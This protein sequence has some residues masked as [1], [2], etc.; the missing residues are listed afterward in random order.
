M[1]RRS[2]RRATRL[3]DLDPQL[4]EFF[5]HGTYTPTSKWGLELSHSMPERHAAWLRYRAEILAEW[6]AAGRRGVPWAEKEWGAD[7]GIQRRKTGA[8]GTRVL[9]PEKEQSDGAE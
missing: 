4:L 1:P 5:L 3:D 7:G 2:A 9:E 8:T 6:N